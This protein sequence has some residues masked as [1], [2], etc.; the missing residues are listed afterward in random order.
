MRLTMAAIVLA[1]CLASPAQGRG[2]I[3]YGGSFGA[4]FGDVSF[5]D[6][7]GIVG[8]HLS[9]RYSVG[10]RAAWRRRDDDR[11]AQSLTTHD[12]GLGVLA[13]YY[14]ERPFY[15]QLELERLRFEFVRPDLSV[16]RDHYDSVLLGGGVAQPLGRKLSIFASALYNLSYDDD[17]FPSPYDHALVLRGGLGVYF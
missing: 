8:V 13:R 17:D 1:G 9:E 10:T 16:A 12:V 3:F 7:S 11:F 15:L 14:P 5:T 6:V 2:R 4:G